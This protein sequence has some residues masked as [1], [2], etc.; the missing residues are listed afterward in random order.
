MTIDTPDQVP[1][2]I[3]PME[4]EREKVTQIP[5]Q[6]PQIPKRVKTSN[7]P[8]FVYK[9]FK[10]K[11]DAPMDVEPT[12]HKRALEESKNERIKKQLRV[13]KLPI[14]FQRL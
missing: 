14:I 13:I 10:S 5:V 9:K 8:Y 6:I 2:P 1:E 11:T 12:S 3:Q 7:A 4:V